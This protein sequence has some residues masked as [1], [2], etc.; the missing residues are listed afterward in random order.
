MSM[1]G[2]RGGNQSRGKS[3]GR[4]ELSNS[5]ASRYEE[6]MV[7]EM[8]KYAKVNYSTSIFVSLFIVR[9]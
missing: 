7:E 3:K 6:T 2:A 4:K 1:F 8:S 5:I 9:V